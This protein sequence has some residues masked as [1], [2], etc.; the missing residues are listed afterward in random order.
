MQVK[1][2]SLPPLRRWVFGACGEASQDVHAMVDHL[3]E[4]AQ[5]HQGQ[6][7]WRSDKTRGRA[8]MVQR[9]GEKRAKHGG[10]EESG[11]DHPG[12]DQRPC[13]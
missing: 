1:L 9:S 2:L 5:R 11:Q 4:A 12:S 6:G 10:G 7:R 3:A 8:G 13:C